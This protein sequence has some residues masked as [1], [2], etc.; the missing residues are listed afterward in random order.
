L[1]ELAM[2]VRSFPSSIRP[3]TP[4]LTRRR[5]LTAAAAAAA[6]SGTGAGVLIGTALAADETLRIA[7]QFGI[8]YLPLHV[9]RDRDLIA[10]HARALGAEVEVEWVKLSGGAAMNEA[11]LS[12]SIDVASGGIAPLLTIWD[13]TR[14]NADVRGIASL[15]ELPYIL[16]SRRPEVRTLA[17]F[18]AED[19]IALPS[20]GVSIQARVLQLAAEQAFGEYER[21]D[22][23]T[24]SLPHPDATTAILSGQSEITAHFGSPPYQDLQLQHPAIHQVLSSYDVLGGPSSAI[25]LYGAAAFRAD[26][27]AS[28]AA[29]RAALAEAVEIIDADKA[30][31]AA[32]YVRVEQSALNG[33]FVQSI[34][35]DPDVRFGLVPQRTET[36]ARFMGRIGAIETEPAD[37][38]DYFFDELHA[39]SGS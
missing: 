14:G 17:D 34:M 18:T 35:E 3:R 27:P 16:T 12:G 25:A 15:V 22:P 39:E 21:L 1:Q 38:R 9:I 8:G 10:R 7:E 6:A 13:R 24:V 5:F 11:L 4:G 26:K 31:A 23:L 36:L 20:V 28:Y 37:W 32:T 30:A 29:L 33:A 19:R 2:P